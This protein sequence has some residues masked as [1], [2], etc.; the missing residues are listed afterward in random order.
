MAITLQNIEIPKVSR[1]VESKYPFGQLTVGGPAMTEQNFLDIHK[2]K[3]RM[4]SALVAYK[5]R[6][7]DKS[8]FSVRAIKSTDG[9]DMVAVW[10]VANAA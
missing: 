6:T 1:T 9:T 10:K 8:K 5:K 4:S 7:G 2:A 3:S